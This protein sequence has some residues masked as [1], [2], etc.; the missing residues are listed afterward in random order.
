ME[1]PLYKDPK[2][3]GP[4]FG[5]SGDAYVAHLSRPGQKLPY[6][7]ELYPDGTAEEYIKKRSEIALERMDRWKAERT[8]KIGEGTDHVS[9]W[10]HV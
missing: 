2:T 8:H 3:Q 9:V 6:T 7:E 10:K 1:F 5:L 4:P